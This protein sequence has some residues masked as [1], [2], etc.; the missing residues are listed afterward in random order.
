MCQLGLGKCL[1]HFVYEVLDIMV[2]FQVDS[3]ASYPSAVEAYCWLAYSQKS[4]G[5]HLFHTVFFYQFFSDHGSHYWQHAFDG[6][7]AWYRHLCFFRV[8]VLERHKYTLL[9][10]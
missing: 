6:D 7:F 2:L 10:L 3:L 1:C 5:L 8:F 9:Q 4:R